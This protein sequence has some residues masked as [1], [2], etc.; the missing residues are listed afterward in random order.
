MFNLKIGYYGETITHSGLALGFEYIPIS[1]QNYQMVFG[2]DLGGYIHRR[3]N[4]SAFIRGKWGQRITV[5]NGFFV[6]HFL[7][8]GYLHQFVHGGALFEVLPNGAVVATPDEGQSR[9]MP[10]LSLGIG[11]DFS[12][13]TNAD[14]SFYLSPELFWK[15]PFNGY[16]LTHFALNTGLIIKL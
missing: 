2:L 12:K 6:D 1:H 11:Y 5:K 16:Y 4:T 3:N 15:A 13:N 9:F 14:L 10:S 8:L 7:G